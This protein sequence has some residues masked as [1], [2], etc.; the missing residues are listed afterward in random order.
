M[1]PEIKAITFNDADM[2]KRMIRNGRPSERSN[3]GVEAA[4]CRSLHDTDAGGLGLAKGLHTLGSSV[5]IWDERDSVFRYQGPVLQ[6]IAD[7]PKATIRTTRGSHG[8]HSSHMQGRHRK[9]VCN[10]VFLCNSRTVPA[11]LTYN[12]LRRKNIAEQIAKTDDYMCCEKEAKIL[13]ML[14]G[15]KM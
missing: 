14:E 2:V 11:P 12:W 10:N 3:E 6:L 9:Y 1:P 15:A 8:W 4:R 13:R 7:H 5:G